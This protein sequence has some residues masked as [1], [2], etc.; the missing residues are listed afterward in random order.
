MVLQAEVHPDDPRQVD[1]FQANQV[2]ALGRPMVGGDL[3]EAGAH[4]HS[5]LAAH[6]LDQPRV[7][8]GA[9]EVDEVSQEPVDSLLLAVKPR[10]MLEGLPE[11]RLSA[12]PQLRP[13]LKGC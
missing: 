2:A 3:G 11:G 4:K 12:W 1:S 9:M 10:Y 6:L 5:A 7:R 13:P 8:L